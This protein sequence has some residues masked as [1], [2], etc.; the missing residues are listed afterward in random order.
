M[1]AKINDDELR[2]LVWLHE[3]ARGF[4]Q[5]MG[6]YWPSVVQRIEIEESSLR[7]AATYLQGHGLVGMS[8]Q[9]MSAFGDDA[10]EVHIGELWLTSFGENYI[11]NIE[12]APGVAQKLTL[13]ALAKIGGGVK[14]VATTILTEIIKLHIR[15][16]A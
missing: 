12:A 11:R 1:E 15:P 16:I 13:S 9:D 2:L 5:G 3:N 10:P 8:V 6:F 14:V 4:G 7:H